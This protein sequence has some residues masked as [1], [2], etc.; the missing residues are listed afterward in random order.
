MKN[1]Q[2]ESKT[3]VLLSCTKIRLNPGQIIFF[4]NVR[5]LSFAAY[6][7]QK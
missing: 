5:V 3:E 7:I 4:F 1:T 2:E 6:Y